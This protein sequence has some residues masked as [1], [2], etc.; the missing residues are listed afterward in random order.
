MLSSVS[1][2]N[3]CNTISL[4]LEWIV[5]NT[6][7]SAYLHPYHVTWCVGL[8]FISSIQQHLTHFIRCDFS[9][10]SKVCYSWNRWYKQHQKRVCPIGFKWQGRTDINQRKYAFQHNILM[11]QC[12][13]FRFA[14]TVIRTDSGSA[15]RCDSSSFW[16]RERLLR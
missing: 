7:A 1:A 15:T 16:D 8:L 3:G 5:T 14:W 10:L 11:S 6:W 13:M 2:S 4:I 9:R 12:Y